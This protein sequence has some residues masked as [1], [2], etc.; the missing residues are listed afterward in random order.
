MISEAALHRCVKTKAVAAKQS[1]HLLDMGERANVEMH[2]LPFDEGLHESL[3]GSFALL[4]RVAVKG[5]F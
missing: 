2:V 3:S 4:G 5:T 1:T